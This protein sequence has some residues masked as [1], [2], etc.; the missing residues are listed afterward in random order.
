MNSDPHSHIFS[1]IEAL[2]NQLSR[3]PKGDLNSEI[4]SAKVPEIQVFERIY[5]FRKTDFQFTWSLMI[6]LV[7]IYNFFSAGYFFGTLSYPTGTWLGL[8]LLS[9]GALL[10]DFFIRYSIRKSQNPNKLWFLQENLKK[11]SWIF[12]CL[13]SFP[14]STISVLLSNTSH[15]FLIV[16]R[17]MKLLRFFQ[18]RNFWK[19]QGLIFTSPFIYIIQV[20]LII[21]GTTHYCAMFWLFVCEYKS[22]ECF[23]YTNQTELYISAF[24]KT[25]ETLTGL[26]QIST[27]NNTPDQKVLSLFIMS[28]GVILYGSIFVKVSIKMLAMNQK[29]VERANRKEILSCWC[30]EREI[31]KNMQQRINSYALLEEENF[32]ERIKLDLPSELPIS[33]R[34]EIALFTYKNLI[35][36]SKIFELGE[37]SF[38]LSMVRS[39]DSQI[40]LP[41]DFIIRHGDSSDSMY[42]ICSGLVEVLATDGYSRIALLDDGNYFGEI[43]ILMT[44]CRTVSI[45]SVQ[46]SILACIS[47][48]KLIKILSNFPEHYE[49][50]HDVAVQRMKTCTKE[51]IDI[52]YDL[53]EDDY[54][55]SDSDNS[56]E[57]ETPQYYAPVEHEH[58]NFLLKMITVPHSKSQKGTYHLDPLSPFFYFWTLLLFIAYTTCVF[59]V[60]YCIVYNQSYYFLMID[61][62]CYIVFVLDI[63]VNY[64]SAIITKFHSYIHEKEEIKLKYLDRFFLLDLL[65]VIPSDWVYCS[66]ECNSSGI[67]LL[68]LLR[69]LKGFRLIQLFSMIKNYSNIS[70]HLLRPMSFVYIFFTFSHICACLI[71]FL[72]TTA[73]SDKY[74]D[75]LYW[76]YSIFSQTSYGDV[77]PTS[78]LGMAL[79]VVLMLVS[80]VFVVILYSDSSSLIAEYSKPYTDFVGKT[81]LTVEWMNHC[82]I[83]IKLRN[84]VICYLQLQWDKLLG[85]TDEE[86]LNYLPESLTTDLRL[87]LFSGIIESGLFPLEQKGAILGIIRKCKLSLI[88]KGTEIITQGEIGLEMFFI[89]DGLVDV[90]LPNT[91]I[92]R[93]LGE[94]S[95]FGELAIIEDMPGIR[96]ATIIAKTDITLAS[97]SLEDFKYVSSL[98]PGFEE[99]VKELAMMKTDS[100]DRAVSLI[101]EANQK[102]DD[103]FSDD[104]IKRFDNSQFEDSVLGKDKH[105]ENIDRAVISSLLDTTTFEN[106]RKKIAYKPWIIRMYKNSMKMHVYFVVWTWNALFIPYQI[107]FDDE[108]TPAPILFETITIVFYLCAGVYFIIIYSTSK[109]H[110]IKTFGSKKVLL[111]LSLHHFLLAVPLSLI[112]SFSS[113]S[114]ILAAVFSYI[115]ITNVYFV[116][117]YFSWLKKKKIFWYILIHCIEILTSF[118]AISHLAACLFIFIGRNESESWISTLDSQINYEIYVNAFYWAVGSLLHTTVGDIKNITG[119]EKILN[120]IVQLCSFFIYGLLFGSI[121]SIISTFNSNLVSW[122]YNDYAYSMK[123]IVKKGIGRKFSM[124]IDEYFNFLWDKNKGIMEAKALENLPQ[125]LKTDIFMHL[126]RET[127]QKSE[128]FLQDLE[129]NQALVKSIYRLMSIQYYLIGDVILRIDDSSYDMYYIISGEV[130]IISIKGNSIINTLKSGDYFGEANILFGT[131][132]RTA[133]V[134]S[135]K[136]SQIGTINKQSLEILFTAYPDWKE[137]LLRTSKDRLMQNFQISEMDNV[138]KICEELSEKITQSPEVYNIYSK[139]TDILIA[140]KVAEIL[141][142]D[143]LN[144]RLT[145]NILHL[146]LI[147]YSC[148]AIPLEITYMS[149]VRNWMI[150]FEILCIGES[151][152]YLAILLKNAVKH[153]NKEV[154]NYY[155]K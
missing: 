46:P 62:A 11:H 126:H 135:T 36:K 68:K 57:L 69:L 48:A 148:F 50:L 10:V 47:K 55:S 17:F 52:D 21:L 122:M 86:I 138:N 121:T 71:K 105:D 78:S 81:R 89:L 38:M 23:S 73:F 130:T 16:V 79:S 128:M 18:L 120:C 63:Y 28:I 117:T 13:S 155:I 84:G 25:S 8:E 80:K 65:A 152:I 75:N 140:H 1:S 76:S 42:F 142:I 104:F 106:K 87:K 98:Y 97:L 59:L 12:L 3:K 110:H 134:V 132:I 133:T 14:Y 109:S 145:L 41:G 15:N 85:V 24:F 58:K 91:S 125:A 49:F 77:G 37:P 131:S 116:K 20:I 108:F 60:P 90:I 43:G 96:N 61:L 114:R 45:K 107:A 82:K 31:D 64:N 32:F 139:K 146:F 113:Q 103:F 151:I 100:I 111:A 53:V 88:N 127:L 129:V 2:S 26:V 102:N 141:Y 6:L 83:P 39:F 153:K 150:V 72:P 7:N 33:L 124:Q 22:L 51:D 93:E 115:R 54:S 67:Y 137:K 4:Y 136:I 147:L 94:G 29:R 99:K 30:R 118:I 143:P 27:E 19:K 74:I 34:S 154:L 35:S 119:N 101:S 56:G 9:E 92:T 95:I 44:C 123:Y 144:K 5:M 40:F 149:S 70:V 112:F 66:I